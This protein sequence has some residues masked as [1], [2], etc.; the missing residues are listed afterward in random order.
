MKTPKTIS[1]EQFNEICDRVWSE[2]AVLLRGSGTLSG[3]A[4]LVRAVFWRLC[5]AGIE[6]REC[7]D[8][9]GST[10]T[11]LAYQSMVAQMLKPSSQPAFDSTP[12]LDGLIDRYQ[13]ETGTPG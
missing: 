6:T 8:I 10:S 13:N 3:E 7:G 4:T 2:R 9:N 12:I 11:L 5:K 1:A